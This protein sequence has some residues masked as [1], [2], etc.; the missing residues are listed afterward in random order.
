MSAD[1]S[2]ATVE[3]DVDRQSLS[4]YFTHSS[5][6]GASRRSGASLATC[7]TR[8]MRCPGSAEWDSFIAMTFR[9]SEPSGDSRRRVGSRGKVTMSDAG[10]DQ[11]LVRRHAALV[12]PYA[13]R[14][15]SPAPSSLPSRRRRCSRRLAGEASASTGPR[16]LGACHPA[17]GVESCVQLPLLAC[18]EIAR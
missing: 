8:R 13:R 5:G 7:Q 15:G 18:V 12:Q 4:F 1:D 6:R 2:I 9:V 11:V 17:E 14:P 3:K 16:S 10:A